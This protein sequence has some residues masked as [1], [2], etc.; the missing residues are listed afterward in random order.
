MR[1]A[2]ML[3]MRLRALFRRNRA[4]QDLDEELRYYVERDTEENIRAGMTPELARLQ[5]V[6]SLEGIEQR[7]EECRDAR[8]TRWLE[9]LAADFFYAW[10]QL[11]KQ[12]LF[13]AVPV[14]TL[15]LRGPAP[16][17]LFADIATV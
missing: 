7:K 11:L 15:A 10:R 17:A 2:N 12:K 5:A 13:S 9:R 6:R 3:R 8:G 1:I 4:E 16:Q 14:L